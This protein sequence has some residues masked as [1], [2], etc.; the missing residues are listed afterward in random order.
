MITAKGKTLMVSARDTLLTFF[1]VYG[2]VLDGSE[3]VCFNINEEQN[4]SKTVKRIPC[5]IDTLNNVICVYADKRE[6]ASLEGGRTY[7][8]DMTMDTLQGMHMT[9]IYPSRF[10]VREVMHSE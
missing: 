3:T 1:K 5:G 8:Y 4:G 10:I 2:A 9:L 7:W 6:M